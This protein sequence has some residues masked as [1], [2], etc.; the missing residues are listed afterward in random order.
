MLYLTVEMDMIETQYR[1][2]KVTYG[3]RDADID[4]E[5]DKQEEARKEIQ[6][7]NKKI[8]EKIKEL[9]MSDN[10]AQEQGFKGNEQGGGTMGQASPPVQQQPPMV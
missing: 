1:T 8:D 5:K 7:N 10:Q 2:G 9:G 6:E 4:R 3:S